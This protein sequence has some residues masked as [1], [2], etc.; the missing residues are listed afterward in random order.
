MNLHCLL[1]TKIVVSFI[2][3]LFISHDFLFLF[4]HVMELCHRASKFQK[5][6]NTYFEPLV[7]SV[8]RINIMIL[9]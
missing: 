6:S 4:L 5:D 7:T 1:V 3:D 8:Q 2:S 9:K